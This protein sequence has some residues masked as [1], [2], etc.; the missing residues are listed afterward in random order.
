METIRTFTAYN[1]LDGNVNITLEL[2]KCDIHHYE[3]RETHSTECTCDRS[4]TI[5]KRYF[6]YSQAKRDFD[7]E[8]H[9]IIDFA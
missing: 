1:V 3:V 5:T 4:F 9:I 8:V 6:N 7:N 2:I